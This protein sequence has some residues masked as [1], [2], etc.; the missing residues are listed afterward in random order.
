MW[1]CCWRSCSANASRYTIVP[2]GFSKGWTREAFRSL[3]F[4]ARPRRSDRV[5]Q[6]GLVDDEDVDVDVDAGAGG[7]ASAP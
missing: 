5:G 1:S 7:A 2:S 4:S 3:V 6:Q